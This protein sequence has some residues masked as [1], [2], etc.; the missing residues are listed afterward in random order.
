MATS[1]E[2][3]LALHRE[4]RLEEAAQGYESLLAAEPAQF[5]ATYYL[6]LLRAQQGR[7]QD[8]LELARAAVALDPESAQA[9]CHL[10]TV[11]LTLE[12]HAEAIAH[13]ERAIALEPEYAQAYNNLGSAYLTLE[14][15]EEAAR[16]YERALAL[17]PRYAEAHGNLAQALSD[18]GKDEEA[19]PHFEAA[20][21][22]RPEQAKAHA[23][24]GAALRTMGRLDEARDALERAIELEPRAVHLYRLLADLGELSDERIAA[25]EAIAADVGSLPP[26]AQ[27]D[28]HFTLSKAYAG[29]NDPERSFRHM[30]AGNAVKRAG[31]E[32]DEGEALGV[33]TNVAN[34]FTRE[35]IASLLGAGDPSPAPI[36]IVGMPRSGSTLVEQILASHPSVY[37]AGELELF[38][39]SVA[40]VFP[41]NG[42]PLDRPHLQRLAQAYLAGIR[43]LAPFAERVT[44]KMPANFHF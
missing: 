34:V 17:D 39:E 16:C 21:A 18:L 8:A 13:L 33:F 19:M 12:R 29:R 37:P 38:S 3:A 23:A 24:V 42:E 27:M 1:F 6:S 35:R 15:P 7:A 2:E 11:L 25:V 40:A 4:G 30:L 28:V 44:D 41:G 9:Q 22:L 32:Y 20:P 14:R 26:E 31:L 43:K 5:G 10:G 36:F